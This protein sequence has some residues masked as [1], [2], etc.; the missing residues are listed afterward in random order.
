MNIL[1][2]LT[3]VIAAVLWA[4]AATSAN[5]AS[6]DAACSGASHVDTNPA[7]VLTCDVAQG[8]T[9]S[10]LDVSLHFDDYFRNPYATDLQVTLTHVATSTAASV[11]VGSQVL[12]PASM[13]EAIFDD[14]ATHAPPNFGDIIGSFLSNELLSTFDGLD[15]AGQW[16][17]RILDD[18]IFPNEGIDLVQWR[19]SGTYVPEPGT[20]VLLAVGLVG[21]RALADRRRRRGL[22]SATR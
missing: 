19:L 15:L 22:A 16:Q 10:D 4:G 3:C 13:M 5:A 14:E 11:Y 20:G 17:L 7:T 9:I 18:W 2:Q 21:L 6:F 8:G 1:R 12:N